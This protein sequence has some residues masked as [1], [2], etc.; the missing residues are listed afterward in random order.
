VV[1]GAVYSAVNRL[2]PPEL[3]QARVS[4]FHGFGYEPVPFLIEGDEA[5]INK[6]VLEATQRCVSH[7]VN[8]LAYMPLQMPEHS[9]A[10]H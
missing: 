7:F 5:S 2:P 1:L 10:G 4:G 9:K 6:S 8:W 3:R